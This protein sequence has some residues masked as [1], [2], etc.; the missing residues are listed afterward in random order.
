[1]AIPAANFPQAALFPC[2]TSLAA[3]W[4]VDLIQRIGKRLGIETKARGAHVLLAPTICLHRS[5]LGGRN[6]ESFSEDP[7]LTG[8][9]ASAYI[10]G[11]QGQNVAAT[12]KHFVGN[13]QETHR[14][15][16]DS[17]ISE[18]AL[19]ELYLKPFEMAIRESQPW[20]VMTAYNALNG[21]H[22]DQNEW[23]LKRVLRGEWIYDG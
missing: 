19:R 2:G 16:V 3:T 17:R 5:P 20:A 15:G 10:R 12:V 9:L 23:L 21:V 22:C 14:M 13:E 18:R 6:F 4:N 1:V 11:L 8:K 7:Y